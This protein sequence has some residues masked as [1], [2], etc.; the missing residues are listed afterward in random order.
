MHKSFFVPPNTSSVEQAIQTLS[1][2]SSIR[3]LLPSGEERIMKA[4]IWVRF[5]APLELTQGALQ[6][7]Q[8]GVGLPGT[9]RHTGHGRVGDVDGDAGLLGEELIDVAE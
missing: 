9:D 1:I 8:D 6:D 7:G 3:F 4:R 5:R 2:G